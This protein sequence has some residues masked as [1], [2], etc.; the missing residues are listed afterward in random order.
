[1]TV[2]VDVPDRRFKLTLHYDGE[3]FHG[4][5][6]QPTVRTIQGVVEE[7]LARLTQ[8]QPSLVA[9]GRTDAGVHAVGQVASALLPGRWTPASL[10]RALN[11]V[12]PHDVW[13]SDVEEV[14]SGFHARYD[15][16]GRGYIYRVGTGRGS[17]SPFQRRWCWPLV[18]ELD[19]RALRD[20]AAL[21]IGTR[22]FRSFARSGQPE[23]GYRCTVHLSEWAEWGGLGYTYRVVANRFLHHMVRYMVGTMVDVAR[24]RRPPGDIG[25]LL[26]A[27]PGLETSPPA[28]AAGL[29]LARV[30]Y[31]E[32]AL[33]R[34]VGSVVRSSPADAGV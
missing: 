32:A 9:A 3:R 11:A 5:Q 21:F 34:D 2:P 20:V 24:G 25:A 26:S 4:W 16:V 1:V 6:V 19:G 22:D 29:C 30:Y 31:D 8:R 17:R 33:A 10:E 15:A 27:A 23:R 28:P 14:P 7:A 13:I 18:A 12:L